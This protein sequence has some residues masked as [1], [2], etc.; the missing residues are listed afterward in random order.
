MNQMKKAALGEPEGEGI[1]EIDAK[2]AEQL[3]KNFDFK[4]HKAITPDIFLNIV[5]AAY[6]GN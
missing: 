5:M 2:M 6:E 1:G 4:N 3:V